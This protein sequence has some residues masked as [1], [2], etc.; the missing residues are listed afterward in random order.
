MSE[1]YRPIKTDEV[2]GAVVSLAVVNEFFPSLRLIHLSAFDRF[3]NE[4]CAL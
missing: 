1:R 4:L 2:K 3:V